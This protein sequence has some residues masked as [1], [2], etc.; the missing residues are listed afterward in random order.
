MATLQVYN[1]NKEKVG[2][3][4]LSDEV[5]GV[6]PREGILHEVVRWQQ[7]KKRA[8]NACTKTRAEVSGG[9]RK[10]WRQKGTGRARVGSSRNPVWRHG[11]TAFGPK[12]RDYSY[13]LPKKV[14]RLGL[15]MALSSKAMSNRLFVIND[16]GI[17]EIKTKNMQA[18]LDRFG[19]RSAV[20]VAGREATAVRLS[21]RNIP[22]VSV[23]PQAALNVYDLL[24]HD[25]LII[26]ESDITTLEER[27][28]P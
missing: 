13:T 10:P 26:P 22:F 15:R 12:P 21:A 11:G 19:V 14:R 2:E 27:L 28:K 24:K 5:F 3:L 7:A 8:G 4:S 16:Y 20:L 1:A 6:E 25:F 23:L 18:L 9:G 17:D